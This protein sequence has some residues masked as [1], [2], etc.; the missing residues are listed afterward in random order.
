MERFRG[1]VVHPQ[2][3]T[4]DVVHAGKRVVVIGSGATAITLVPELAK[5]AAHVTMLQRSPTYIVSH[6]D[7]DSFANWARERFSE[8][9]AYAAARWKN[10]LLGLFFYQLSRRRPDYVKRRVLEGVRAELGPD[11]D[12]ATHF[13]PSY[14]PWDQRVCLV[15]NGDL[16]RAIRD[17]QASVVT[18]KIETFTE[19]GI[20][21]AS[22]AELDA[23]LV[24][25]ATGLELEVFGGLAVS[26][27]GRRVDFRKDARLQGDDVQ[28]RA[29]FRVVLRV[30]ERV[31]DVEVRSHVRVRLQAPQSDA[32]ARLPAM[33]AARRRRH[34]DTNAVS[35]LLFWIHPALDREVS[36]SGNASAVAAVPELRPRYADPALPSPR[37]RR[38]AFH[39]LTHGARRA[40]AIQWNAPEFSPRAA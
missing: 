26:V 9:V 7:E 25:T 31:L 28:R 15:P 37:G 20:E 3:W 1:Q 33:H 24:V 22:G 40:G 10:V 29:E 21:L 27:D 12:V 34:V 18:D 38:D 13:T 30:H 6:P 35:R 23:D 16:F 5:T 11:Y 32:A 19:K 14:N 4:P 39:A 17:G 2:Q 36:E 8:R